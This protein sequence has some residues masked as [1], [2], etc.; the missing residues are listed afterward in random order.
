MAKWSKFRPIIGL[1]Q[2]QF[3]LKWTEIRLIRIVFKLVVK[4][5]GP[6]GILSIEGH[7]DKN[8]K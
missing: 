8:T 2:T 7:N 1:N 4:L 6:Y 3:D 5:L